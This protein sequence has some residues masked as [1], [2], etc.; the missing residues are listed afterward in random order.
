MSITRRRQPVSI[1]DVRDRYEGM[2]ESVIAHRAATIDALRTGMIAADSRFYATTE[3]EIDAW[4]ETQRSELDNIA[5]LNLLASAEATLQDDD[6][7]RMAAQRKDPLTQAYRGLHRR[8]RLAHWFA[9]KPRPDVNRHLLE[10]IRAAGIV[11]KH[12]VGL[13]RDTLNLRH[14]LAH[15]RYWDVNLGHSAYTPDDIYRTINAV[16]TRLPPSA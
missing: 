15:G 7:T 16:L 12:L 4:F 6:D 11:D 13:F 10:T 14:W 3:G 8:L 1:D 5:S 9:Q 2:V